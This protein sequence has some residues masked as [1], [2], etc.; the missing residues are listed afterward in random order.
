MSPI[1]SCLLIFYLLDVRGLINRIEPGLVYLVLHG[2]IIT[3]TYHFP[4]T[5]RRSNPTISSLFA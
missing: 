2:R 4:D 3:K 1:L 5:A